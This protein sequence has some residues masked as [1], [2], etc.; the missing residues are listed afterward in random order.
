MI[1]SY[2]RKKSNALPCFSQLGVLNYCSV[3]VMK[4][5]LRGSGVLLIA[6]II[7]GSAFVSQSVGMDHI[8]PF[9][10]QAVRCLLAVIGLLPVIA[11]ADRFS[12]DGKTFLSR[13]CDRK[14]WKAG[15]ICAI[16]LF[17]ACNLQQMGLVSTD[18]GK[19]GFL[20]AMYIV[21]VPIIGIFRKR[22]PSILVPLSVVLAVVGLYFLSGIGASKVNVG[23]LLTLGCALMFAIQITFID[24][25]A[26]CVDA[27]RLNTIQSLVCSLLSA[28][29]MLF[30]EKPTVDGILHASL[31]LAHTGFLSMGAAYALQ[32]IGQKDLE[33]TTAAL[34]MSLESVFAVIFALWLLHETMTPQEILGCCL[35]FGAVILSQIPVKKKASV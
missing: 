2:K 16:P 30:T 13:W 5:Q 4:K 19:S 33:P 18:A 1:I 34:I 6:T 14:L 27:L 7:W 25:Y 23:D 29:V 32:I 26:D 35:L 20:T 28:A 21:I 3:I 15:L 8:G 11:I 12:N 22:K 17:L 31:P 10:F 9:T 24:M